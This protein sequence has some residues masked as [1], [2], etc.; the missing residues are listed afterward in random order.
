VWSAAGMAMPLA[1]MAMPLAVVG[2]SAVGKVLPVVG[3]G[4]P[5]ADRLLL[6][7][8]WQMDKQCFRQRGPELALVISRSQWG[9]GLGHSMAPYSCNDQMGSE[10]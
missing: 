6:A 4:L 7:D 5:E 9:A 3:K 2:M 1:G 10:H 8:L